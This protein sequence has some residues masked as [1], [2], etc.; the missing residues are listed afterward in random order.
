MD[1]FF[2]KFFHYRDGQFWAKVSA[3]LIFNNRNEKKQ[4]NAYIS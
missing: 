4:Q 3:E 1:I 2:F